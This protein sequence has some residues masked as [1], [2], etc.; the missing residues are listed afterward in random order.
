MAIALWV[1]APRAVRPIVLLG[2]GGLLGLIPE[3]IYRDI[4]RIEAMASSDF[5]FRPHH[6]KLAVYGVC[7][8]CHDA[9]FIIPNEGLTCPIQVV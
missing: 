3:F 7:K 4:H 9:G 1:R 5:G 2:L 8:E 6:H